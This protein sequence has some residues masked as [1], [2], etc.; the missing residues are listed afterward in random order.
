M[1]SLALS[2]VTPRSARALL[3]EARRSSPAPIPF[4]D[5]LAARVTALQEHEREELATLLDVVAARIRHNLEG[6][7]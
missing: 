1:L 2:L 5:A 3:E 6:G 7:A 4:A